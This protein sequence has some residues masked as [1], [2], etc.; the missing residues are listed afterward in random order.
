MNICGLII[1]I[2]AMLSTLKVIEGVMKLINDIFRYIRTYVVN[3]HTICTASLL[4]NDYAGILEYPLFSPLADWQLVYVVSI[5][6]ILR[7]MHHL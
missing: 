2:S 7:S 6:S 4:Y 3:L 1:N 5:G